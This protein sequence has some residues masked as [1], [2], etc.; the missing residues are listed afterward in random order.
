MISVFF[1]TVNISN[2]C[3]YVSVANELELYSL[4]EFMKVIVWSLG[5]VIICKGFRKSASW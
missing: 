4:F 5:I 2:Y 1:D 3:A